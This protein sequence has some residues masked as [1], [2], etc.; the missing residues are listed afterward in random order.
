[1]NAFSDVQA[2]PEGELYATQIFD[3]DVTEPQYQ[4][5]LYDPVRRQWNKYKDY[6]IIMVRFDRNGRMYRLLQDNCI[7]DDKSTKLLCNVRDFDVYEDGS[8]LIVPVKDIQPSVDYSKG[9]FE[10]DPSTNT[11]FQA[12]NNFRA[13]A[14]K[15]ER[16]VLVTPNGTI[17]GDEGNY[18]GVCAQDLSVGIDSSMWILQCSDNITEVDFPIL[19]W[20]PYKKL[21]YKVEGVRG[22]KIAA[23]NEI[24][25]AI[26]D[27]RGLLQISSSQSKQKTPV[28]VSTVNT[29][30]TPLTR[31]LNSY[32]ISSSNANWVMN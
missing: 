28:F 1:M 30:P 11:K 16:P 26:I 31:Q 15:L 32:W 23:Y 29:P 14:I 17:L 21:W 6:Q 8:F 10:V 2:S 7:Y 20:N 4:Q 18:N 5:Y 9:E 3:T 25:L 12:Y 19:K 24:S 27:S 13:L 22:M